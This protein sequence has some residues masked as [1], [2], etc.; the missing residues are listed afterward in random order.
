MWSLKDSALVGFMVVGMAGMVWIAAHH[1]PASAPGEC[2]EELIQVRR[3]V[4]S[5][6]ESPVTFQCS[7]PKHS[8]SFEPYLEPA[9]QKEPAVY[10]CRCTDTDKL[11]HIDCGVVVSRADL[12][13]VTDAES[14]RLLPRYMDDAAAVVADFEG[15]LPFLALLHRFMTTHADHPDVGPLFVKSLEVS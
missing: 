9:I 2:R 11:L 3:G 7:H 6:S 8:I 4:S 1:N 10:V 5:L 12:P 15:Y 14:D 13:L